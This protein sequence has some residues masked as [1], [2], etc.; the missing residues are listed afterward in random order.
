MCFCS[1]IYQGLA[2]AAQRATISTVGLSN[3]VV[4]EHFRQ[5]SKRQDKRTRM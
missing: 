1:C 5:M 3:L 4:R 2:S